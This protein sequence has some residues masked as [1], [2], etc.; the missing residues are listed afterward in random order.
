MHVAGGLVE[1]V[2]GGLVEVEVMHVAGGLVEVIESNPAV[3]S[4]SSAA[5][6]RSRP[7]RGLGRSAL[8]LS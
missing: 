3:R 6:R 2:A 8:D 1:V 4:S 5:R 7:G